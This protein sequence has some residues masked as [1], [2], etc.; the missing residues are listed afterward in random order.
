MHG[1]SFQGVLVRGRKVHGG[2]VLSS[3]LVGFLLMVPALTVFADEV[4][5]ISIEGTPVSVTQVGTHNTSTLN[6][7][8]KDTVELHDGSRGEVWGLQ[9]RAGQCV[10]INLSSPDFDPYLVL[11]F[12]APFGEEIATDDD[13][14]VSD[15]ARL[16]GKLPRTGDYFITVTSSGPGEEEGKYALDI[17]GC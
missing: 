9:G 8:N 13:S 6:P 17:N 16:Y 5:V 7:R 12:G 11:R 3:L 4:T 14:G 2:R 1:G 15:S 10:D